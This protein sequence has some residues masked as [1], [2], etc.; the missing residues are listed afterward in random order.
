MYM[1][2]MAAPCS[3]INVGR[4]SS[5][6]RNFPQAFLASAIALLALPGAVKAAPGVP[7]SP[8]VIWIE[9]F[10]NPQ[11]PP[12]AQEGR[13]LLLYQG[14][15]PPGQRY[16]AD[17]PWRMADN[18]CNG[19]VASFNQ[20]PNSAAMIAVC[21]SVARRWNAVQQFAQI[22]GRFAGLSTNDAKNNHA[23]G[24]HT[25]GGVYTAPNKVVFGTAA[26]IPQ[27][28]NNR[29]LAASID[30]VTAF[31]N[32]TTHPLMRFSLLNALGSEMPLG[33]TT[34]DTC[35]DGLSIRADAIG[36]AGASSSI[37]KKVTSSGALLFSSSSFGLRLYNDQ[38]SSAGNDSAID[39][40]RLLDVTPQVDKAFAPANITFGQTSRLTITITN[41]SDLL[42]KNGWS[43]T[44]S[45]PAGLEIA[46]TATTTC[47]AGTTVVAPSG[48][49]S[50]G[51][52]VGNLAQASAS[53]E[54]AVDVRPTATG[55]F[56]NGA[57]NLVLTG[58]NPPAEPAVLNVTPLADMRATNVTLPTSMTVGT[59]VSGSFSCTNAGPNPANT[60]SC[61]IT[62]LPAGAAV[63][64]NPAVPTAAPLASGASIACTVNFTPT[65][66]GAVT[67]LVTASSGTP[68]PEP[69]NN[70]MAHPYNPAELADM[71]ATVPTLPATATVGVPVTGSFTCTNA[72]PNAAAFAN[73]SIAGLPAGATTSCTPTVPTGTPLASGASIA[74]TVNFTPATQ[75]SLTATVTATSGTNDPD[76]SNN[77]RSRDLNVVAAPAGAQAIP[78]TGL[79]ALVLTAVAIM[80]G[81]LGMQRRRARR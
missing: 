61:T 68:D 30:T 9:D 58:L 34:V 54:V 15:T 59:P 25:E 3:P 57:S 81:G 2:E 62:G 72:G 8:I 21:A 27:G 1:K 14:A 41:T 42:A 36:V 35:T 55:S 23:L 60:A 18:H 6:F 79:P 29:F 19:F 44:D 33:G 65:T 76:A 51:V 39:N 69:A 43:F 49:T 74:C 37:A 38:P 22:A 16:T 4:A 12:I 70:T 26:N 17:A 28:F 75:G 56:S 11:S 63:S 5:V 71:Q 31:C 32:L 10:E 24:A 13:D 66:T 7:V 80:L 46:G 20:D 52:T 73:C 53:C 47:A 64:C 40:V 77:T 45:L 48:G 50:V 78:A 67:A